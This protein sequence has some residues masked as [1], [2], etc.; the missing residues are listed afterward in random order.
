MRVQG[1]PCT[2]AL[3]GRREWIVH[4]LSEHAHGR[5]LPIFVMASRTQD[6][7]D[8]GC[9][10]AGIIPGPRSAANPKGHSLAHPPESGAAF[11]TRHVCGALFD[12]ITPVPLA[13]TG[14]G[15]AWSA[16]KSRGGRTG[17]DMSA[18]VLGISPPTF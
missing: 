14:S 18:K 17:A 13:P 6:I 2:Y 5:I 3:A 1:Q 10:G 16:R 7:H 11:H 15:G 9:A 12:A 8:I 4:S